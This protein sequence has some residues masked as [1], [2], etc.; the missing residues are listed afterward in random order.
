MLAL[1]RRQVQLPPL[2]RLNCPGVGSARELVEG[3]S[4]DKQ[5]SF[6]VDMLSLLEKHEI[7][8]LVVLD[9][10]CLA[11]K[12]LCDGLRREARSRY[13]LLAHEAYEAGDLA[14]SEILFK[15]AMSVTP[16]MVAELL[17]ELRRLKVDFLVAPY[18]ADAQL[19]HL[20]REAVID[21]VISEDSDTIVYGCKQV[22]RLAPLVRLTAAS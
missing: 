20:S 16:R 15:R 10:G 11:A 12:E 7:V 1:P 19:A 2:D 13:R 18:E 5:L 14:G 6:F 4:S 17:A 22:V 3:Q 8:P 9:G 21:L